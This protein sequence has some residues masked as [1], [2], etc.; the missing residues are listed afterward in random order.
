[1][2]TLTFSVENAL[3]IIPDAERRV[4]TTQAREHA[5]KGLPA[6]EPVTTASTYWGN[7]VDHHRHLLWIDTYDKRLKR[8][9]R[10]AEK[11]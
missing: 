2:Q 6:I 4:I 9:A 3:E 10:M 1:M 5:D 8:L 11:K 7:V